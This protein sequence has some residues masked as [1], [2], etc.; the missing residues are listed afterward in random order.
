M[1]VQLNKGPIASSLVKW[2]VSF[3][4]RGSEG[5][6]TGQKGCKMQ[7]EKTKHPENN[8]QLGLSA[9]FYHQGPTVGL[10]LL[11]SLGQSELRAQM[12]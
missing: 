9:S 6:L 7:R 5:H 1:S 8:S 12:N 10:G 3:G 4:K 2:E 11:V